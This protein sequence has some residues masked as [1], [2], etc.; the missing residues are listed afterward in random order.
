MSMHTELPIEQ[1]ARNTSHRFQNGFARQALRLL[2]PSDAVAFETTRDGLLIRAQNEATL[3]RPVE[4]LSNAYPGQLSLSPV[5]VRYVRLGNRV[6][7]PIM[8][9]RVR[10]GPQFLES[11]R[12]DLDA[13]GVALI[14]EYKRVGVCILRGEAPLRSM[15]GYGEHFAQLTDATG[16]HWTW[17]DR[18]SPIDNPPGGKA[19]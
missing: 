7:E 2:D 3:A 18:Y 19:A 16:F 4:L 9:L 15:L 17:L 12:G 5:Q 8:L 13:R 6:Y 1:L 10:F 11:V 14:E